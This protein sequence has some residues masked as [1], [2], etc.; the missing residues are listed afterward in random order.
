MIRV[1]ISNKELNRF[2]SMVNA[3]KGSTA[4]EIKK[5]VATTAIKVE[6]GAKKKIPVKSGRAR[7]SISPKQYNKGFTYEIGARVHYAPYLEFG[8]GAMVD[9]P[10]GLEDYAAQFKGK[11]QKQVNI[12]AKPFLFNTI[13]EERAD[14]NKRLKEALK[15]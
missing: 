13:E 10:N 3:Y 5:A 12:P 6:S 14:H 8:T 7:S 9:V 15:S 1:G 11:G 4:E 2:K